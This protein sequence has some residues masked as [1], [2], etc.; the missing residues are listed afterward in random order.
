MRAP[1]AHDHSAILADVVVDWGRPGAHFA[2]RWV[3]DVFP[4][5]MLI[6]TYGLLLQE[7]ANSLEMLWRRCSGFDIFMHVARD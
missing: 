1:I 2:G 5:M 4:Y 6:I 3:F 7:V